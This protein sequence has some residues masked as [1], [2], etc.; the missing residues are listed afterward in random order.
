MRASRSISPSGWR[1]SCARPAAQPKPSTRD[2]AVRRLAILGTGLIGASV[3]LAAKRAGIES[4]T[5]YDADGDALAVAAERGAVDEAAESA[6]AA[7]E[8]AEITLVATPVARLAADVATALS[9]G[10]SATVT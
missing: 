5:G 8:D 1:S 3:G 10:D 2:V 4:I 6:V 7:V 9:A